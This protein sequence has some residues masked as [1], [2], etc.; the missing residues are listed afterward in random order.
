MKYVILSD[1]EKGSVAIF[2]TVLLRHNSHTI[3]FTHS[4]KVHSLVVF[5]RFTESCNCHRLTLEHYHHTE[6]KPHIY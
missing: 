6:K 5:N 1:G 2:L 3:K 4:G